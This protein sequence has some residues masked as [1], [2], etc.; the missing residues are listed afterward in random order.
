M[1]FA[2]PAAYG[3]TAST[4]ANIEDVL[5]MMVAFVKIPFTAEVGMEVL[6]GLAQSTPKYFAK[7]EKTAIHEILDSEQAANWVGVLQSGLFNSDAMH[8][9]DLLLSLVELEDLSSEQYINEHKLDSAIRDL[10]SLLQCQGTAAVEDVVC[11]IALDAFAQIAEGFAY[12]VGTSPAD[13]AVKNAISLACGHCLVKIRYPRRYG[14][15]TALE[16]D[17][18]DRVKFQE[19]R[20]EV[21]DFLLSAF[22]SLGPPLLQDIINSTLSTSGIFDHTLDGWQTF[23]A[24]L[25]CLAAFSDT[26]A[27]NLPQYDSLVDSVFDSTQFC[28]VTSGRL[29]GSDQLCIVSQGMIRFIS[30]NTVYLHRNTSR[31]LPLLNFLFLCLN[32][33]PLATSASK[34]IHDLCH[35]ERATLVPALP[36]FLTTMESLDLPRLEGRNRLFGAVGAIIQ[37]LPDEPAKITPLSKLLEIIKTSLEVASRAS[38]NSRVQAPLVNTEL[39]QSLAAVGN[40]LRAPTEIINLDDDSSHSQDNR[41]WQTGFG[42]PFQYSILQIARDALSQVP[43]KLRDDTLVEAYCD[44]LR[45]G[46][47][48]EHPSPF[49]FPPEASTWFYANNVNTS[50]PGIS[51]VFATAS[52]FLASVDT[53]EPDVIEPIIAAVV[54]TQLSII[55]NYQQTLQYWDHDF[56]NASLD[57]LARLLPK[58]CGRWLIASNGGTELQVVLRFALL[59]LE[60]PDTLPRRSAASFWAALL[61]ISGYPTALSGPA[62]ETITAAVRTYAGQLTAVV[63]RLLGGEC[64]RSEI[65]VL[66]EPLKRFVAKHGVL[67]RHCLRAAMDADAGVLSEKAIDATDSAVRSRFAAQV[68]G[69]RGGRKTVEVVRE[70][71]VACRGVALV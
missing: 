6:T 38:S 40:G 20:R 15:D 56:T 19:F 55:T 53:N 35:K 2:Q 49:K 62:L 33:K 11:P 50:T 30:R 28:T 52:A 59:S 37:A 48:E 60:N 61:D 71:W 32:S 58:W 66:C 57:F 43:H 63:L 5:S 44:F 67:A 51:Y 65:D 23:E 68:E 14:S 27:D 1:K 4:K 45:V 69:L 41:F 39:L 70:F 17:G 9:A 36:R 12:W 64:A 24:G 31:L 29:P 21:E 46:Y 8:Y 26:M 16:W 34:A 22:S 47:T 25:F 54:N 7:I 18:D 3:T 13:Y 42:S 10:Q